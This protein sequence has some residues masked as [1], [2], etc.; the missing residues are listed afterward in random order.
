MSK[1]IVVGLDGSAFAEAATTAA[2]ERAQRSAGTV[3]G[4]AVID[5]PGIESSEAGAGP[6]AAYFAGDMIDEKLAE[7]LARTRDFLNQFAERCRQAN[8]QYELAREEGVPFDALI[9]YGRASDLIVV[10]LKT[11]FHFETSSK[12]GNTISRL[13]HHPVTPVLAVPE[14]WTTPKRVVIAYNSSVYS[15]RAMG[16][17]V[18]Q[19]SL[20]PFA[21]EV[22]LLHVDEKGGEEISVNELNLAEKYLRAYG[23]KVQR[24]SKQGSVGEMIL[25]TAQELA[26]CMVVMGAFH[27]NWIQELLSSSAAELLLEDSRIPLFIYH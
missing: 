5:R 27:G 6:G 3:V 21:D 23:M 15:S 19:Q 13:I 2:I 20:T 17:F 9:E 14:T 26:P 7:A 18:H 10:G 11:F 12:P 8:V 22:I 24:L 16:A 1:R 25:E 4:V